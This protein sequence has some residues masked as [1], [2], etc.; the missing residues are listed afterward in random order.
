MN[1]EINL[2][3][4]KHHKRQSD[5]SEIDIESHN[6]DLRRKAVGQRTTLPH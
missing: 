1:I 3:S 2:D 4:G 6:L 5:M